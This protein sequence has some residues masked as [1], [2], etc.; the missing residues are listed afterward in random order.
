MVTHATDEPFSLRESWETSFLLSLLDVQTA[1]LHVDVALRDGG[2]APRAFPVPLRPR[3]QVDKVLLEV[4]DVQLR[5][6]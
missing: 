1:I 4:S 3:L 6:L 5:E 2:A